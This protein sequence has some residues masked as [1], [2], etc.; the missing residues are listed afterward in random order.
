MQVKEI[1]FDP[2][3]IETIDMSQAKLAVHMGCP[4]KTIN[5]I[6][7]Y[8]PAKAQVGKV[9]LKLSMSKPVKLNIK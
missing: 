3:T 7:K 6:K 2:S 5:D 4:Q 1:I 9:Y 8:L